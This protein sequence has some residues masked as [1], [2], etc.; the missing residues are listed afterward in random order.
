MDASNLEEKL[1]TLVTLHIGGKLSRGELLKTLRKDILRLNQTRYC[2]LVGIGRNSLVDIER[3]QGEPSEFI[4]SK[5]FSPFKLKPM[6]MRS[7]VIFFRKCLETS[8]R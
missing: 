8:F 1:I 7:D 5:A 2:R 4:V 3:D 6:M